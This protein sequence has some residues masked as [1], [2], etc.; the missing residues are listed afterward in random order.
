MNKNF[1]GLLFFSIVILSFFA[2]QNKSS[3]THSEEH[4]TAEQ[5][6]L[7]KASHKNDTIRPNEKNEKLNTNA[8]RESAVFNQ[9][10]ISTKPTLLNR[11]QELPPPTEKCESVFGCTESNYIVLS[12]IN[13]EPKQRIKDKEVL[14]KKNSQI[15]KAADII[16]DSLQDSLLLVDCRTCALLLATGIGTDIDIETTFAIVPGGSAVQ[17]EINDY[18]R[19]G[20]L[21]DFYQAV[22][23]QNVLLPYLNRASNVSPIIKQSGEEILID[24]N[25]KQNRFETDLKKGKLNELEKKQKLQELEKSK[26][27]LGRGN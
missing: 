26:L 5:A 18:L 16:F 14:L 2:C 13:G 3:T 21:N 19:G 27:E 24:K 9:P 10:S 1:L 22:R 23:K 20:A 11:D 7:H 4:K 17:M 12:V 25:E 8:K 15:K 6:L